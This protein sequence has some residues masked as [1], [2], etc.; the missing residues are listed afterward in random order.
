[1]PKK[2][3]RWQVRLQGHMNTYIGVLGHEMGL[4]FCFHMVKLQSRLE[5]DMYAT[6]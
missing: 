1:M 6:H 4:D 5:Q 3:G 2:E